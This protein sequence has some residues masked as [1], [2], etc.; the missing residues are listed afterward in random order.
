M[1]LSLV[2]EQTIN[3]LCGILCEIPVGHESHYRVVSQK[4]NGNNHHRLD[5]AL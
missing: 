5:A 3:Q 1:L 4:F 2:E